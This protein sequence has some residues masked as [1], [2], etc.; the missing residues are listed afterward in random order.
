[1]DSADAGQHP[2][3]ATPAQYPR[4]YAQGALGGLNDEILA[5][6]LHDNAARVYRLD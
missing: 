1:M 2:G 5:K 4:D 6:V 3:P